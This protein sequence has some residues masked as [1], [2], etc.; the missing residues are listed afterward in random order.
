M[1]TSLLYH[2]WGVRGYVYQHCDFVNGGI[3][4]YLNQE[5]DFRCARC[6]CRRVIRRGTVTRHFKSLPVG[7]KPVTLVLPVQRVACSNCAALGQ[8]EVAFA[9]ARR[10]YT[11]SFER[12]AVDLCRMATIDDVARRLGVSWDTIKDIEK[13]YLQQRFGKPKLQHLRLIAIDEFY[14]G[15]TGRFITL[16]LDLES[17]AIVFVG[18]G[19]GGE[20]LDPF[21]K[22]LRASGAKIQAVAMDMSAAYT[23]AVADHLP[24][25]AVIF[26]HFHVIKLFNEKLTDLRREMFREATDKLHKDVLKGTR[27]LLLKQPEH[28]DRKKDE[29]KRLHEALTLNE[30]LAKAYY[31]R[32]DLCQFWTQ[33]SKEKAAQFLEDW[34]SRASASGVRML[35]Q[36]AKTL[37]SRRRG[38]LAYY[39]FGITTGKLEGT[40]RKIRTLQN[41]A[42]GYRDRAFFKLKLYALHQVKY[43]LVG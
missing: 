22:R 12:Y 37:A 13:R 3:I 11:K 38:L 39:D 4:F 18:E 9:E 35:M 5:K 33:P 1:S 26:D 21:W 30:P 2:A 36:F 31:L 43:A 10:S 28:L 17:G 40:N 8:V 34:I 15:K 14:L 24:N 20:A 23:A 6:G 25:A 41:R 29:S 27:W 32:E 7:G 19:K 16:V 42:Y